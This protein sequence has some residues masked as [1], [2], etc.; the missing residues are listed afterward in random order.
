MIFGFE[1]TELSTRLKTTI[2]ALQPGG[3]ILFARN[4]ESARQTHELLRASQSLV[5]ERMFLCVDLEGGTVDRLRDAL[6][7]APSVAEV[8]AS[9][10]RACFASMAE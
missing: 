10:R 4:I 5:E 8:A 1:G 3:L 9:G 7:P 6:A 2:A